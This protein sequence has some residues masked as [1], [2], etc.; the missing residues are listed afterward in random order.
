MLTATDRPIESGATAPDLIDC[1]SDLACNGAVEALLH[2]RQHAM[3]EVREVREIALAPE[4]LAAELLLELLDGP[5]QRRL[6][7][8]ALLGRA[9]EI[10]HARHRQEIS[11]LVHFHALLPDAACG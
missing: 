7:D 5:R 9:R 2:H 11:D 8:V 6:R 4:Q 10:E 3:A 1:A